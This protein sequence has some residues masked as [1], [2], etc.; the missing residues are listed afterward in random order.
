MIFPT[1]EK[2]SCLISSLI[3]LFSKFASVSLS[4]PPAD[5]SACNNKTGQSK[6]LANSVGDKGCESDG[7]GEGGE[8]IT[9][10]Y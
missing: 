6:F 7:G 5:S 8:K 9:R 2:Y 3:F 1:S 4:I 10:F